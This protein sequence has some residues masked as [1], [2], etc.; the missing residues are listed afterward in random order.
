MTAPSNGVAC[1][2][3]CSRRSENPEQE[4][5]EL[6]PITGKYRCGQC[7]RDLRLAGQEK[8]LSKLSS[9]PVP[10]PFEGR[11]YTCTV[12]GHLLTAEVHDALVAVVDC[13]ACSAPDRFGPGVWIEEF[14][15]YTWAE[16]QEHR[17]HRERKDGEPL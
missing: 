17:R 13:P 16:V 5:W 9:Q 1:Y 4:G 2:G 10:G 12:C 15:G 11:Y 6:L 8:P 14:T 7:S 3:G